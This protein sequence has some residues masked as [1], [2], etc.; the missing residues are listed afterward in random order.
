M[1]TAKS[2]LELAKKAGAKM[3]D[4]K[5]VNTRLRPHPYEFFLYH[6]V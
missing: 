2:V 3:V 1:S 5:F 4:I 6:D